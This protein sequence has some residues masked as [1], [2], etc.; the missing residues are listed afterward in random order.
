MVAGNAGERGV[1]WSIRPKESQHLAQQWVPLTDDR[2]GMLSRLVSTL[3]PTLT[4]DFWKY[5]L[6]LPFLL[7]L[8][9]SSFRHRIVEQLRSKPFRTGV[10]MGL[11]YEQMPSGD[12]VENGATL[13]CIEDMRHLYT[14]RPWLTFSD[15]SLCSRAWHMGERYGADRGKSQYIADVQT[16]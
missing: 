8:E 12:V 11:A 9:M 4:L 5:R 13:A 14:Q 3:R 10:H 7:L 2:P 15:L 6:P 16:P 1:G